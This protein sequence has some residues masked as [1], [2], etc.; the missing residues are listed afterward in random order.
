VQF[1]IFDQ[2]D[3]G[4]LPLPEHYA[5]RLRLVEAYDRLGFDRYHVS[6]HHA[7]PLSATP[8][9]GAWLGAV[10]QRTR[11]IRFGPLVYILPMRHPLQIA[12]EVALLDQMSGGRFD[13][14]IGR[15]ISPYELGYHGVNAADSPAMYREA[16]ALLLMAMTQESVTFEGRWWRC[17]DVPVVLRPRQQPHPPLWYACATPEAAVWPARNAVNIVCNAPAARVAEIVA[18]YRAEWA[19]AGQPA[20]ALPCLGLSRA[21]VLADSTAEAMEAAQRGWRRYEDSF[22]KL[23]RKH[24]TGPVNAR[25]GPDFAETQAAGMGFAG[26]PAEVRD[27]LRAQLRATGAT[28]L[29]SRFAFGDLTEAEALRSAELFAREVMPALAETEAAARAA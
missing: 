27:A 18:R 8:A 11:R 26:T 22:H 20:G 16:L 14:G 1:G 6:E 23:W 3:R 7:T 13:I 24:G 12:E 29:V 21:I 9:T 17:D 2:N 19:A 5:A 15:G 4:V 10:A 28:Y 25:V